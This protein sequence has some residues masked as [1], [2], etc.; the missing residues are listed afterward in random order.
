MK[1]IKQYILVLATGAAIAVSLSSCWNKDYYM[2]TD[3]EFS[4]FEYNIDQA[5]INGE[6]D[7]DDLDR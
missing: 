1:Q 6:L 4:E 5:I 7:L 3:D 2:F